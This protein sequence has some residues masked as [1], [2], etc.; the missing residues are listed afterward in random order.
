MKIRTTEELNQTLSEEIGWRKK[1]IAQ[2]KFLIESDKSY[3]KRDA[4]IRGAV[5]ILYA[6]WEGFVKNAATA[7]LNYVYRQRLRYEQL[8]PNFIALAMKDRIVEAQRT[9]KATIFTEVAEF[10]LNGLSENAQIPWR[11]TIRTQSNLKS[12][13]FRQIVCTLGLD[14]T[15]YETKEKVIDEKLLRSRNEIAHGKFLEI[16]YKDYLIIHNETLALMELFRNQIDNA[17]SEKTFSRT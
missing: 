9:N 14:Y 3:S 2:F 10:F 17:A 12:E 15:L 16:D 4:L 13:L 8:T 11:N 1:E 6:H 7:Y 5:A